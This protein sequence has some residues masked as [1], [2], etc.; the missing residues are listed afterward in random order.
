MHHGADER[1]GGGVISLF[2]GSS[3]AL[4]TSH[5]TILVSTTALS[6]KT[7]WGVDIDKGR[8]IPV[9]D[10]SIPIQDFVLKSMHLVAVDL[11]FYETVYSLVRMFLGVSVADNDVVLVIFLHKVA[12]FVRSVLGSGAVESVKKVVQVFQVRRGGVVKIDSRLVG[13]LVHSE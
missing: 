12:Q 8:H 10:I 2:P 9:G 4:M 6:G 3:S 5:S 13:G 11:Q 7:H 1:G